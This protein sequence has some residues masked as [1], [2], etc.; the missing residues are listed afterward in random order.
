MSHRRCP[1]PKLFVSKETMD[2]LNLGEGDEIKVS[3]E[4]GEAVL[5]VESTKKLSGGTV[6]A[7]IHFPAVRRLFPWKLDER[8]GEALLAP[9]P[10][11]LGSQSEKS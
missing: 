10:V 3:T 4:A 9:V 6:A 2:E 7:T 8:R 1:E 11:N 5:K